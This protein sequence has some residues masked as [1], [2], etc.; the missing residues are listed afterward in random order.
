MKERAR[1]RLGRVMEKK[2]PGLALSGA[3]LRR[4]R[5]DHQDP[6]KENENGKNKKHT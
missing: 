4:V 3:E 2:G 6:Q 5:N 1:V